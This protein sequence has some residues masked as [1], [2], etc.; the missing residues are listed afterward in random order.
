MAKTTINYRKISENLASEVDNVLFNLYE[1]KDMA[2]TGDITNKDLIH[3]LFS[4]C[5]SLEN[6]MA[7]YEEST[8]ED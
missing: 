3:E 5:H 4:I 2:F 7:K 6:A 1:V 8:D